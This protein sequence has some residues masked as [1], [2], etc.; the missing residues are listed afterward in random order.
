MKLDENENKSE[1][2]NTDKIGDFVDNVAQH[3]MIQLVCFFL[4]SSTKYHNHI[5]FLYVITVTTFSSI[6]SFLTSRLSSRLL[7]VNNVNKN[8]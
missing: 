7:F 1:A 4:F 2:D 8:C 3:L 6:F 5:I